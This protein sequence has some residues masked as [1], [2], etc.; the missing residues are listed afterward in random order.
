MAKPFKPFNY[1]EFSINA[2]RRGDPYPLIG[3]F[4]NAVRASR[5]PLSDEELRFIDDAIEGTGG[6]AGAD[7][8]RSTEQFLIARQVE[9]LIANGKPKKVAVDEVGRYRNRSRRHVYAA[10]KAQ[11][12]ASG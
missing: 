11:R 4:H 7:S 10:L 1:A 12:E 2:A 6:K 3:R 8:L 9:E 5:H